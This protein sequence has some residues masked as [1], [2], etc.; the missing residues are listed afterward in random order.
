MLFGDLAKAQA[1]D[2]T[3][4]APAAYISVFNLLLS[5]CV[6]TRLWLPELLKQRLVPELTNRAVECL[7]LE[8]SGHS[9]EPKAPLSERA[10]IDRKRRNVRS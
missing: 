5:D 4:A 2:E 6:H 3:E 1:D 7:V 10:D 8:K 9:E